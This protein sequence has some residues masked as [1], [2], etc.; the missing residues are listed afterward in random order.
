VIAKVDADAHKDLAGKYG[1]KGFPTLKWFAAGGAEPEDYEGDRTAEALVAFVNGKTGLARKLKV[2]PSAVEALT[3]ATFDAA[4]AAPGVFKLLE[5]YAPWCGHCK[6]LAPT[7][8]KLAAA[9]AGEPRVLIAKIDAAAHSDLGTRFGVSGYPTIKYIPRDAAAGAKPEDAALAY[10]G[11]RSLDEL[12]AF[13]NKQAGTARAADGS[14][15]PAA[16]RVA[17]LDAL[18]AGFA[19][20]DKAAQATARAAAGA[21]AAAAGADDAAAAALYLKA[22]DKVAEKG[23]AYV[24]KESAR[25]AGI[26]AD[27]G[28][29]K[30]KRAELM[31]RRNVLAAFAEE[32]AAAEKEL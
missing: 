20:A 24:A 28:V 30:G 11:G 27:E 19:R 2:A 8:E 4:A 12:V 7:Y 18:A 13:V 32:A 31:L 10:D 26:I 1:V 17:A 6:A 15:L 9:F 5:F 22:F 25:L 23:A 16:G 21:A 29:D 3:P 14:L